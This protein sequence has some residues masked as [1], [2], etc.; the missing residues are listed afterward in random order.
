VIEPDTLIVPDN[1]ADT[2]EEIAGTDKGL[3]SAEGTINV[4]KGRWKII[5]YLRLDDYD[6]NNWF[7]VDSKMMKKYLVWIERVKPEPNNT[8][9]F[10]T[11]QIK[12]SVYMRCAN[13]FTEWRFIY[14]HTVS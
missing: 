10:E 9:D 8:I 12:H 13:G 7:M 6:T 1:L 5:P 2:A 4:Q 14:G 3:Y 11:Y